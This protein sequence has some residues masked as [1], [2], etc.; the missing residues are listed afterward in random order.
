MAPR[1]IGRRAITVEKWIETVK[2]IETII[3]LETE[4]E[5]QAKE[6]LDE[7]LSK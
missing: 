7:V 1:G 2:K 4:G 3:M 5:N 6:V